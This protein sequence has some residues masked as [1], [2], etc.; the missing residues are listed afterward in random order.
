MQALHL[1]PDQEAQLQQTRQLIAGQLAKAGGSLPFDRF[2]ELA[3]YAPGAGYY[4]NG[5]HKFGADGDFITAPEISPMFSQCLASQCAQVLDALGG[6]EVLE[7]G[8]GSGIMAADMLLHLQRLGCLPTRYLIVELSAELQVRQRETIERRAPE[9]LSLVTWVQG[10]PEANWQGVVVAN[11]VLDA[12]PVQ[13]FRRGNS[14]WQELYVTQSG[15]GF[16]EQWCEPGEPL[17]AALQQLENRVGPLPEGY[18]SEINLRLGAWM[19]LLGAFLARGAVI[20]V[21][22]GYTGAEYYHAER[23]RGTMICHLQHRA[24]DNPL[25]LPGLQDITANVD[26]SAVA[27]A[28]LDAGLELS[29][30]TT[31]AHFLIDNGLEGL[32]SGIDMTDIEFHMQCVQE[33]KQ[34]TLPTEMGERFKV[35]GFQRGLQQALQGFQSRDLRA[36]L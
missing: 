8:A 24:H 3:L 12:M 23:S 20:L 30:Y 2:M 13:V 28:G 6:G 34:L 10:P 26:F 21:D 14:H 11:E 32:M 19:R 29:G 31:Q 25:V 15:E 33:L 27:H 35:I 7:F 1:H 16:V 22:Y 18:R 9:L 17:L 36:Y 5:S 4:V